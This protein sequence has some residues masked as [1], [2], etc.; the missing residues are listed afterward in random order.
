MMPEAKLKM[1]DAQPWKDPLEEGRQAPSGVSKRYSIFLVG[2]SLYSSLY[3]CALPR[4]YY[5]LASSLCIKYS[6]F[7][8]FVIFGH[9]SPTDN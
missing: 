6:Y 1:V 9:S 8:Q 2:N 5:C 7:M 4:T 3:L